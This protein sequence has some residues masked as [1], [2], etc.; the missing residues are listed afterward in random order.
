MKNQDPKKETIP[1]LNMIPLKLPQGINPKQELDQHFLVDMEV[2]NA[3]IS[4]AEISKEDTVV[5]VGAGI[6]TI[7]RHIPKCSR[8]IAIEIDGDLV[9]ELNGLSRKYGFKAIEG[10]A[11]K[12]LHNIEF[13]KLLS[14]LPYMIS[15][16]LFRLLFS[17]EF[18]IA[19]LLLPKRFTKSI[20]DEKTILGF[21]ANQF[22]NIEV[23]QDVMPAS[24]EPQPDIVSCL[25]RI[26]R[27]EKNMV[28]L[29]YLQQNSLV[30]NALREALVLQHGL[31]K[32]QA[33]DQIAAAG[34]PKT[35]L[36]KSTG[37]IEVS[38]YKNIE[39]FF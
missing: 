34:L 10:N 11:L 6:G 7:T 4:A 5:D 25:V 16:P 18:K 36:E 24:Y 8:I 12:E 19:V 37:K 33:R 22:F 14:N 31:T 3:M 28:Q 15:E 38:E 1:N 13:T 30:K 29:I 32:R 20:V 17:R 26:T 2:I 35:L 23:L 39:H 9:A 27:K 21:L